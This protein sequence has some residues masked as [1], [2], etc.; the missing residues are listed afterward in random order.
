MH[1]LTDFTHAAWF[2][3]ACLERYA[4]AVHDKAPLPNCFGF[5]DGTVRAIC[6]P[7][8][9]QRAFYNGHKGY[10]G[11]NYQTV[12]TPDGLIAHMYGPMEGCRHDSGMLRQSGL[13]HDL[14]LTLYLHLQ[15]EGFILFTEILRIHSAHNC[16]HLTK[17]TI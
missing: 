1:L 15:T 12:V 16:W 4:Q 7:T 3:R 8:V 9:G 2:T 17:G 13:Q 6:R 5:I 11:V 14:K 10:H